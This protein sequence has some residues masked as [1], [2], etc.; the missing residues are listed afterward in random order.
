MLAFSILISLNAQNTDGFFTSNYTEYREDNED[1]WGLEM[2]LLP[3]SHGALFDYQAYNET[4]LGNGLILLAGLG[5]VY[6]LRKKQ[7]HV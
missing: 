2:P 3:R 7:H 4:P 6:C 5:M 1:V